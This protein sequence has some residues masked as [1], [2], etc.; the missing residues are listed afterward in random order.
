MQVDLGQQEVDL[1]YEA[2]EAWESEPMNRSMTNSMLLC[3]APG[4]QEAKAAKVE[5]NAK[6]ANVEKRARARRSILLKA[7][8]IQAQQAQDSVD[9]ESAFHG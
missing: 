4:D 1:L 5:L 8:L 3:I 9:A 2:L 6:K 7:K